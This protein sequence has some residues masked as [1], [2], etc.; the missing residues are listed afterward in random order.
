MA[1][2]RPS[3]RQV[4]DRA[5][6]CATAGPIAGHRVDMKAPSIA[7]ASPAARAYLLNEAATVAYT[8]ADGG[9]IATCTGTAANG[10][11]LN[12]SAAGAKTLP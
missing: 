9:S 7:I 11:T 12:T 10:A 8:C 2:K 6:N 5:G 3:T 1:G 4:C